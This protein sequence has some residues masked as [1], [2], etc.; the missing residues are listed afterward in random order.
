MEQAQIQIQ[1]MKS[2]PAADLKAWQQKRIGNDQ[3]V[4]VRKFED[5]GRVASHLPKAQQSDPKQ[6]ELAQQRVIAARET[7]YAMMRSAAARQDV[8][9]AE[10]T[11]RFTAPKVAEDML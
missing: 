7:T 10:R 1:M 9:F 2:A 8:K 3:R 6:Q 11:Q 5:L 4:I